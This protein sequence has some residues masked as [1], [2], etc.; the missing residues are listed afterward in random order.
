MVACGA[1]GGDVVEVAE[2]E[3]GEVGEHACE[4]WEGEEDGGEQGEE[5]GGEDVR[6]GRGGARGGLGG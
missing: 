3:G 6:G 4:E 2:E 5:G 1:G